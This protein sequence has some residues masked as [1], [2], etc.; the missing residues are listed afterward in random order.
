M[1]TK[2]E[3]NKNMFDPVQVEV[4][5][6]RLITNLEEQAKT[7]IRTSFSNIL[8][9]AGDLSA[10]LFDSHGNMIA[11]ANTG[12]PGHINTM[13]LGVKHFMEKFPSERLNHGDVLIGN[14][15][16]E[17]SGHLLDVTIVTPVFYDANL[18]GYFASTCHVTDIGGRGYNPE[19]ESIYEEGLHIPYMKYYQAGL[20]NESLQSII[21]AN[22]R[23]PFEVLGDLRAQVVA[24]E[25]AIRRLLEMLEE[26]NLTE[27]DT[28]GHEIIQRSEKA[29]RKAITGIPDGIYE[30]EIYTDGVSEPIKIKCSVSIQGDEFAV[31]FTGSSPASS[32]GVNVSLYY[33]L[34][35]VTYAIK[36]AIAPDIPNN[37]G[38]FRPVRVDA[39]EGCVLNASHPMPTAARHII[40]HFAPVCVLGALY[41]AMPD[42]TIAEGS[43]SIWSVQV[44]GKDLQDD[45]FS[46]VT[47]STGGMGARPTKD[48]LSATGFPSGV[49]G[50]P[51]EIIE[52]NSPLVI[53]QKELRPD[54]G[55]SGQYRGG[56]G[57]IIR[58]GVRTHQQ[59]HFPTMFD[60][61]NYPPRGLAGGKP[62]AKAE[63]LLN[64]QTYL[65]S[66]RLYTFD[67][68][69]IITL[70]LPGGGGYDSPEKR[71]LEM[72][73]CDVMN[74]YISRERANA[75]YNIVI[76]SNFEVE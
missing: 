6:N 40:G 8:S 63:V 71:D 73:K 60:C 21:E 7:L 50:T 57:Q 74:G 4:M 5:W 76:D 51:V 55:G 41:H 11:Q 2:T 24:Q 15:P 31:D 43:T 59:W 42:A 36:A 65:E 45:P 44:Y 34:A 70:K 62:G 46:Y 10:G 3:S 75:D 26:F 67:P 25:V 13:A 22:V 9:D 18:I 14:N 20:M 37:E 48:G 38:S 12:T 17:I 32:K 35:Y 33:T 58:F 53:Y 47:F 52:S 30:N 56:L 66:K 28:L 68:E 64:D 1:I 23:A 19:G 29:M 16:Y 27:I 54:S 69:D 49:R 61:M 72:V 39:P